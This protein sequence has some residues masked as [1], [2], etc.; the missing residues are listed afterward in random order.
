MRSRDYL[1][2]AAVLVVL[3]LCVVPFFFEP[4][5]T[6][7]A[8][9]RVQGGSTLTEVEAILGPGTPHAGVPFPAA[10]PGTFPGDQFYT[11]RRPQRLFGFA[12]RTFVIYV[13]FQDGRVSSVSCQRE[14]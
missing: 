13:G 10:P 4:H 14:N 2:V 7:A 9:Q 1:L 3:A 12:V 11:W 5:R 8:M 6:I